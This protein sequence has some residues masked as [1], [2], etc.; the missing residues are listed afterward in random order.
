MVQREAG[1]SSVGYNPPRIT[2]ALPDKVIG[3][4]LGVSEEARIE[5]KEVKHSSKVVYPQ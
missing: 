5:K 2:E 3:Q 4:L 1:H